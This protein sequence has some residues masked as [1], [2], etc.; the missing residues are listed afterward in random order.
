MNKLQG[1]K[2]HSKGNCSQDNRIVNGI[3]FGFRIVHGREKSH[4]RTS[5]IPKYKTALPLLE[6]KDQE[7]M[8]P[9]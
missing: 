4:E 1:R 2:H 9:C 8:I 6:M 3:F 7:L 5:Y